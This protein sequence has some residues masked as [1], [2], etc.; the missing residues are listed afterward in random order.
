MEKPL[1]AAIERA[2]AHHGI[3][4]S[5]FIRQ[6]CMG[7]LESAPREP[8]WEALVDSTMGLFYFDLGVLK[9]R[10]VQTGFVSP[11]GWTVIRKKIADKKGPVE[12]SMN[13]ASPYHQL[14]RLLGLSPKAV[15][16]DV[17]NNRITKLKGGE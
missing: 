16:E 11:E 13:L 17:K 5:A 1:L 14:L 4:R 3:T 15:Q 7:A 9:K 2:S 6:A 12:Q 10:L 8:D